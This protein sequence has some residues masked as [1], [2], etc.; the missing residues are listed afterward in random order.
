M[1]A[2]TLDIYETEFGKGYLVFED[3]ALTAHFLPGD[4]RGQHY[5]DNM[6]GHLSAG[7]MSPEE[8]QIPRKKGILAHKM[9]KYFEGTQIDF[10]D[11]IILRGTDF[12]IKVLEACRKVSYGSTAAYK[13][14]AIG[15]GSGAYGAV[16]T[17]VSK[18]PLPVLIP[19]HRVIAVNGLGGWS[20]PTGMKEVLLNMEKR[21]AKS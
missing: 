16:G 1:E 2:K 4:K 21:S 18:N 3:K 10:N 11:K 12:E 19:C 17:A 5:T 14:L 8:L 15:I 6:W 20:G 13:D 9:E 7:E